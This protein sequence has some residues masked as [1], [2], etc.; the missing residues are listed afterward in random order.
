MGELDRD[1]IA[2]AAL[3]VA[4]ERGF[5]GF[6]MRAVAD[7]L[8]VTPMALYH[9]VADKAALAA[10]LVEA[11]INAQPLPAPT[12]DWREDLWGIAQWMRSSTRAHPVVAHIRRSYGVWTESSLQITE[13]WLSLWQQS[14]LPLDSAVTAATT[15][16]LAIVGIV[17][18]EAILTGMKR[19]S[20]A[21]LS[22][23][24]NARMVFNARPDRDAN[25]ELSVRAL[26]DG[27]HARLGLLEPVG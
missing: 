8:G 24:P 14:G 4:D 18:E 25:F 27:L 17:A 3:A 7:A 10:L 13:R 23:L 5:E 2:A 26:I 16:S 15:S 19:P 21:Q 12:G 6:T 9:H 11:A 22:W 20:E 1:R